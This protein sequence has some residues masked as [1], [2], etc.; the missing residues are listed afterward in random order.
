MRRKLAV[1]TIL[2]FTVI[3]LA[4][5]QSK[6]RTALTGAWKVVEVTAADGKK[7]TK[8][9]PSLYL[10][11]DK[12]YSI[13]SVPGDKPRAV[14]KDEQKITDAEKIA[15]YDSFIAN[16][17]TY[18]ITGATFTTHVIVARGPNFMVNGTQ[19]YDFKV[20]GKTLTISLKSAGGQPA[21]NPGSTKLM[22]VE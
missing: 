15:A 22:K 13:M 10:F 5:G 20:E 4:S 8:V 7:N 14:A 3:G 6:G 19:T 17:G 11:T 9:Q 16:S 1:F 12:H 2:I 18:E 21:Q